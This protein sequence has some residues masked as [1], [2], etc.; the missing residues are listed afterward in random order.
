MNKYDDVFIRDDI[1][2][3]GFI[4]SKF[5]GSKSPDIIVR[6]TPVAAD[7]VQTMFGAATYGQE[8][9]GQNL[10][11]GQYNYI[12]VRAKN[13]YSAAT[14]AT[15]N[16][17]Y[18]PNNTF[19]H[20]EVWRNNLAG[21]ADLGSIPAGGVLAAAQPIQW[22]PPDGIS[23]FCLIGQI[24]TSRHPNTIPSSF[25]GLNGWYGWA[26]NNP[27]VA[28]HNLR[29]V[30]EI[31]HLGLEERKPLLNPDPNH[32]LRVIQVKCKKC[33]VGSRVRI[34][35]PS[36]KVTPPL[37]V[38]TKTKTENDQIPGSTTLPP[39]FES[40]FTVTFQPPVKPPADAEIEIVE[41]TESFPEDTAL[42]AAAVP[43]GTLGERFAH[44]EFAAKPLARI[45]S[46]TLLLKVG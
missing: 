30:N 6:T 40:T 26:S 14:T 20:P 13:L 28:Y 29:V 9:L 34:Y 22:L 12:Y 38:D 44:A 4:P 10:E 37:L 1:N 11:K 45:G 17:Y 2:D 15:C 16:L 24:V 18:A 36:D 23:N 25:D 33:P 39:N 35:S 32:R 42:L 43:G 3:Q 46:Y 21:T 5:G 7:K 8:G 41:W 19:N 31:P 27:A